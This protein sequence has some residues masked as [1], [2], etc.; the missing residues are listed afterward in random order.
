M[1]LMYAKVCVYDGKKEE[2]V[3]KIQEVYFIYI[4]YVCVCL[5]CILR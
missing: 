2:E 4:Q 1:S 3:I 5:V